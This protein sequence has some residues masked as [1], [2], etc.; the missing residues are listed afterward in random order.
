MVMRLR[1]IL[2]ASLVVG[3]L[4]VA[5]GSISFK[6]MFDLSSWTTDTYPAFG[7]SGLYNAKA[8]DMPSASFGGFSMQ[9]IKYKPVFD[10]SPG[11]FDF[12][13]YPTFSGTQGT[14]NGIIYGMMMGSMF[15][16]S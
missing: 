8:P 14:G 5:G 1:G 13:T 6:P 3:V 2:L 4:V 11:A 7:A 10:M 15:R 9:D 16:G 12:N